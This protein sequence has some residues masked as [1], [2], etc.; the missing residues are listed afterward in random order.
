MIVL[1]MQ[2]RLSYKSL[3]ETVWVDKP[4]SIQRHVKQQEAL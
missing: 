4:C 3:N 1:D 2:G